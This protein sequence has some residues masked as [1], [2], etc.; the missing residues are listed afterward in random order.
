MP[1]TPPQGPQEISRRYDAGGVAGAFAEGRLGHIDHGDGEQAQHEEAR[2]HRNC[3]SVEA[4]TDRRAEQGAADNGHKS[5]QRRRGARD[6]ADRL[7]RHRAEIRRRHAE[8][9]HDSR[10]Q[11]R[12]RPHV[13]KPT[14]ESARLLNEQSAKPSSATCEMRRMP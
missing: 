9:E 5:L 14:I 2:Q 13:C 10:G 6:A 11:R 12:E 7:H 4:L 3:R 1:A 8:A